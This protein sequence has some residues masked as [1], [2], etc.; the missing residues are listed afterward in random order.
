MQAKGTKKGRV[1]L[2]ISIG[3]LGKMWES[4][5]SVA[6][7]DTGMLW[8]AASVC[9]FGFM[10]SGELTVPSEGTYDEGAHLSFHDVTVDSLTDPQT[11]Q[12]R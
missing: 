9:F 3:V 1:R 6:S 12:I 10:R 8:A 7:Q 4:W 2:P 11:I 5:H